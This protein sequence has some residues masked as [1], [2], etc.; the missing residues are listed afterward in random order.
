MF[1]AR[2]FW[3]YFYINPKPIKMVYVSLRL[4]TVN[5]CINFP[6]SQE[7]SL[8]IDSWIRMDRLWW[9]NKSHPIYPNTNR[10]L[11]RL[12]REKMIQ[13]V[14]IPHSPLLINR[15]NTISTYN[16]HSG[17]WTNDEGDWKGKAFA[18]KK[19]SNFARFPNP[20]L[21]AAERWPWFDHKQSA[22]TLSH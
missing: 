11:W 16:N 15:K 3:C 18:G 22:S 4:A 6:Q 1:Y 20:S 8:Q 14:P 7:R 21:N 2:A 10:R 9:N 5:K 12:E 13:I 17:K 19:K